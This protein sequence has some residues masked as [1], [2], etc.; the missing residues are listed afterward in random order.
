[1]E[2]VPVET[3]RYGRYPGYGGMHRCADRG[4]VT[5]ENP[6]MNLVTILAPARTCHGSRSNSNSTANYTKTCTVGTA[7]YT[8]TSDI[9][10]M[11]FSSTSTVT[12]VSL[13]SESQ[14]RP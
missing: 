11:A 13:T 8:V 1:M 2:I 12:M 9:V 7:R 10:T 4:T 3:W 5:P 14:D 6:G